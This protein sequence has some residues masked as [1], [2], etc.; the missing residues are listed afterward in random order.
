MPASSIRTPLRGAANNTASPSNGGRR[1]KKHFGGVI[2]R[3]IGTMMRLV[4][5]L[6]GTTA[7][8]P[9]ERGDYDSDKTACLTLE[10]LERW[11]AIAITRYYHIRKHAGINDEIPCSDMSGAIRRSWLPVRP[12]GAA[13]SAGLPD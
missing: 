2:E 12:S 13:R 6:P 8:A 10:E 7:P 1:G 3:V 5:A 11:L 9:R 4:H